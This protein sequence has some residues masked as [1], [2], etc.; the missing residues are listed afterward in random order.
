MLTY[1]RPSGS[2]AERDFVRRYLLPLGV[3]P[4]AA[5]NLIHRIG[6]A[7]VLWSCHTDTVHRTSGR[8][9]VR[10]NGKGV[11]SLA[12]KAP[13]NCLG[14]DDTA[15]VWLLCE[16]IRAGTPGLYVFHAGEE[17][18]GKGS[19][20]IAENTP[21]LLTGIQY[22]IALDRKGRTSVITHQ[23]ARC[24]SDA[25]AKSLGDALKLGMKPDD[26]GLFTDTANYRS[27]VPE[28]SNLSVGY[29]QAHSDRETLDTE[30][31]VAL[32]DQLLR[33][34]VETLPVTRDPSVTEYKTYAWTGGA[35]GGG[36]SVQT[37]RGHFNRLGGPDADDDEKASDRA[38]LLRAIRSDPETAADI[39]ES[40]GVDCVDFL[41]WKHGRTS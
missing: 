6:D 30:F 7:P 9:M 35:W 36:R 38:H 32:R 40:H 5:G 12:R 22:A 25:F 34:D 11:I 28:C 26:S 13:S 33:L 16:M 8:Q 24:C 20:H 15:G 19:K 37:Q 21:E 10:L 3:K 14:A 1:K 17:I 18:G 31:L 2:D 41:I 27:L 4:D 29:E 39:L 23:G